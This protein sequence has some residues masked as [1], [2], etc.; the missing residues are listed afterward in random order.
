[1][2]VT[3]RLATLFIGQN[4]EVREQ[5]AKG[6]STFI[7]VEAARLRKELEEQEQ[8]VNLYRSQYRNEL[9]EQ[10]NSNLS[11]VQQLRGELQSNLLRLTALEER[12]ANLEQQI[13]GGEWLEPTAA[14]AKPGTVGEQ[15]AGRQQLENLHK[16]LADL[17]QR[18]SEKHPDVFRVRREIKNLEAK[19]SLGPAPGKEPSIAAPPAARNP[20]RQTLIAQLNNLET[21]IKAIERTNE[22]LKAK[23]TSYQS[24]TDNAPIRA[25]EL[26]KISRDYEIT[27][28]KYQDLL[29]KSLDSRLSENMEKSQKGEQ[30]RIMEPA[31]FPER[32]VH[33]NRFRIIAV[34]LLA[35][36]ALGCAL[37]VLL[38]T[39][40]TSFKT[41]EDLASY[42]DVS[43]LGAVPAVAT[44]GSVLARRQ[45]HF[46]LVLASIGVLCVGLLL[47]RLFSSS[48]NVL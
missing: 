26:S 47:I 11:T 18:Y 38:E 9:P 36:I 29:A 30:F 23:I 45:G 25:I 17:L 33:P 31:T 22:D 6:T 32:P 40:D 39:L 16:Q 5:Q 24:R 35:G 7:N 19:V 44:R 20:I 4:L 21:E 48:I 12:K 27:L 1:M 41:A 46:L 43:L 37:A 8:K 13:A 28:R 2:Q 14:S 42:E 10:L 34:G 3:A 15:P